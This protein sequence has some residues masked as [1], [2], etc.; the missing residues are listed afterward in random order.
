VSSAQSFKKERI[1]LTYDFSFA[2]LAI[3]YL[4]TG[5]PEYL[6]EISKLDAAAHLFNH[7]LLANYGVRGSKLELV[8]HLLSPIDEQRELLPIFKRNLNF[9]KEHLTKSNIIEEVTLQFLP[10]DFTFSGTMFFTFGYN[11]VAYG[12]NSSLNLAH[13]MFAN[14]MSEIIYVAI[15]E[16]HHMGFKALQD[17]YTPS[18]NITT[19]KEMLHLIEY[20]IHLEGMATYASFGL[21][22]QNL[23]GMATDELF[24]TIEIER[25]SAMNFQKFYLILQNA[26]LMKELVGDFF[27][28]YFHFKN[29]PDRLLTQEDTYKFEVFTYIKG[30]QYI[31]GAHIA[32]TID[33]KIGREKLI[34][35]ISEPSANFIATY[36]ELKQQE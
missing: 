7:A 25:V 9:V 20:C 36:L 6:Y 28:I 12:E 16:L 19:F 35:L 1:S 24:G 15:H 27:D 34:S 26:Q 22:G 14:N 29:E 17:D 13:Q 30:L 3:K 21:V 4:E 5:N 31:V 11:S 8:T 32:K 2:E 33:E 18:L 23:K 10:E